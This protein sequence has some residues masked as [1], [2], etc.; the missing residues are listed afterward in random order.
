[1]IRLIIIIRVILIIGLL[2]SRPFVVL[3]QVLDVVPPMFQD[4]PIASTLDSI[5]MVNYFDKGLVKPVA[6]RSNKFNFAPDSIPR[7]DASVYESRL[8]KIDAESPFDL[9][10]NDAVKSYIE[11]YAMRKRDLVSRV[12]GM[13]QLYFPMIEQQLD[14]YDIPLEMK[15][16]AIVESALNSR[17]RSRA[18]AMGLWQFM[19]STGKMY[20]LKVTSYVD[21]RCD[22]YKATV[23]AC[24]YLRFLY[25][26]FDDWQLVLAAYNSGPGN[27]NKAIRRSG[28]KKTY[29]EIRPYLPRETQGY[30]PAFIA[31]NYVMR[32]TAEHNLY[33][34]IPKRSFFEVDTVKIKQQ[35]TFEQV[36]AVLNIPVEEVEFLNPQYKKGIIPYSAEDPYS[37]C[38][39][40]AKVGSFITNEQAIYAY[41]KKANPNSQD[42]LAMQEVMKVHTVRRGEKLHSIANRYKCTIYDLKVWN[43]LKTNYVKT[44]QKLTVYV[45]K[46]ASDNATTVKSQQA[47]PV[48]KQEVVSAQVVSENAA[49]QTD[50]G[51]FYTV[52]KGDTLWD[53][54]RKTGTTIE[55]IKRLNNFSNNY[56]LLPGKKIKVG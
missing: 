23:A 30:V 47:A 12:M 18:G 1:M 40:A 38:L 8:A 52:G 53:I 41:L 32:N 29:W 56:V 48:L 15:Y 28:G 37:L 34:S 27:V 50:Q 6:P 54:A 44:G 21:E 49:T 5:A 11:M 16:L 45:N 17:V 20:D 22:P 42:I 55:E 39:P 9:E 25:D 19:Y 2:N 26:M 3:A 10:Y 31:V 7:Y 33:S 4:D 24:E 36:S 13:S 14:K 46:V 43:N 35:I 51:K